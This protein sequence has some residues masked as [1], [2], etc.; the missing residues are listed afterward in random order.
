MI[1][2]IF[3]VTFI[4]INFE[5]DTPELM[6]LEIPVLTKDTGIYINYV[7]QNPSSSKVSDEHKIHLSVKISKLSDAPDE[8]HLFFQDMPDA[9]WKYQYRIH[10]T[11]ILTL[12]QEIGV[13]NIKPITE[14]SEQDF[15]DFEKF[16]FGLFVGI[17]G[18]IIVMIIY[19]RY[20][21]RKENERR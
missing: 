19:L 10:S 5:S 17:V 18:V 2:L 11:D 1:E 9:Y 21:E 14:G 15:D 16:G 13:I 20:A 12:D 6:P 7:Y 8:L 4:T 3:L